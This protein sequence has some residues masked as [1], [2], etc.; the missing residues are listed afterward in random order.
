MAIK[1]IRWYQRVVSPCFPPRCK[2]YP[3]CSQY[4][5]IAIKRFGTVRG[6]LLAFMRLMRCQPWSRGGI[7]DVP[8]HFSL[9]YR[10]SWSKAHEEPTVMPVIATSEYFAQHDTSM[11]RNAC[12]NPETKMKETA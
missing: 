8:Q 3:T 9:F 12:E 5:L 10:L 1:A 11:R 7:D 4:T 6:C 2:Y